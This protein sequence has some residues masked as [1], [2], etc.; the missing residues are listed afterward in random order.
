MIPEGYFGAAWTVLWQSTVANAAIA[1]VAYGTTVSFSLTTLFMPVS[2]A[3]LFAWMGVFALVASGIVYFGISFFSTEFA[4]WSSLLV[5]VAVYY[6][7]SKSNH[8]EFQEIRKALGGATAFVYPAIASVIWWR[9][10][11]RV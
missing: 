5:F 1:T 3:F 4:R 7:F 11:G 10:L 9:S 2:A 6:A 8:P